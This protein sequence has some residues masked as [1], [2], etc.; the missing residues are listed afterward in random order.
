MRLVL[1]SVALLLAIA[2]IGLDRAAAGSAARTPALAIDH[3]RP[4]TVHGTGF[5]KHE[6]V[7]LVLHRPGSAV[8]HA[9]AA[10]SGAFT[11]A[12]AGVAVDRCSGV[13]VSAT[14]SAGSRATLVRR[15]KPQCP[16]P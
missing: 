14:G 12:F 6:R 1:L 2:A 8:R 3:S 11:T 13:W 15:A 16:P 4:L 5:R 10:A 7:R 9:T